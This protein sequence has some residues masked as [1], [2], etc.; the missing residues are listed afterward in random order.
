MKTAILAPYFVIAEVLF[1]DV[2]QNTPADKTS[3]L[4]RLALNLPFFFWLKP[5]RIKIITCG[6]FASFRT[7]LGGF[8]GLKTK[9]SR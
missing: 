7:K 3:A 6:A 2:L 9:I 5:G 8:L 4:P 1:L